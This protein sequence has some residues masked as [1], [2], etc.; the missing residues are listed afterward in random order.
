MLIGWDA[1]DWE[2]L[3]PLLDAGKMPNLLRLIESGVSGRI[4]TLQP[5]LSPILWTS[6]ATGKRGDKHGVLSF[7]EPRP[8][9]K[10]IQTVGSPSRRAK[11][12][13]NILSQVGRRSVVV[14]W[15]ASHPAE[16][17]QGAIVSNH[18]TEASLTSAPLDERA[19]HP[20]DLS[21]V[22]EQLRV[23]AATLTPAQ[24][25]PFFLEKFP[26][27]DDS[28][29]QSL[30]RLLAQC[31]STH[32]AA[33]YLAETED[34]D[35]LA[36]Y[37]DMIDH[38]GHGY[39]HFAPP[40]M[41]HV[42]EEDFE[43]FRHVMESTYR[44]HD[45][46]LGRWMELADEETA[47]ILLSDHG[48]YHG[49]GRPLAERGHASGERPPGVHNNPLMWHRLHGVVVAAG[50]GIKSDALVQSASLL[51]VAPTV[52]AM[53]GV[54]VP[55]DF[56]GRVLTQIFEEKIEP[57]TVAS[58]EPPHPDDGVIRDAP[59]EEQDPWAAQEA[60]K[61]LVE[62]GYIEAPTADGPTPLERAK[63]AH[64]S[65][66]AQIYFTTARYDEALAILQNLARGS[67]DPSF[68]CREAMCLMALFRID[69][70]AAII[71]EVRSN[72]PHY[73]LG[74]MTAGQ[75]AL[76]RGE[77]EQAERLFAELK[78][79]ESQMP[80]LHYQV[81]AIH[82]RHGKWEEAAALFRSALAADPDLADAHDGLG[83]A[84]RHLGKLED[85]IYEHMR[86]ISLQHERAQTHVN[87]GISLT[88]AG[89]LQW[90]IRALNVAAELVPAEPYPHRCL[91]RIYRRLVPDREKARHH[92]LLAR[93]LRR[94]LG[95]RAPGLSL[96]V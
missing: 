95:R 40:R 85:S 67:Q 91:A 38:V 76:M 66:L 58:Y 70:A 23:T 13:W 41:E 45:L 92:L 83:V 31:A 88:K 50:P 35:F 43:I 17:I 9:G 36:A 64:D 16:P 47:I 11:A 75:L 6:I 53:L 28:R 63:E 94:K 37:Y 10:G 87:L 78:E 54:P 46:M 77:E 22:M 81:G 34:W 2:Y 14:N 51:D 56:E 33:T 48:F 82:L 52:L 1:A 60:L 15:F 44:Y 25:H 32:N 68:R 42:S 86:A 20:R 27:D 7:V 79:S 4:A 55:E 49:G 62:L 24:M 12:L 65:H 93:D 80:M 3:T 72:F 39:A 8:D 61:Q 73:S 21:P 90:A 26:E 57:Q 29:L 74:K 19:F 71:D 18:F 96:G 69:E 89:Q 59:V 5:I 30:A 84:L